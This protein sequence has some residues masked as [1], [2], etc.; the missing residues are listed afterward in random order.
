MSLLPLARS[1][2]IA[3]IGDFAQ[4]A[5]SSPLGT[6]YSVP[7]SD[8][9]TELDGLRMLNNSDANV[10][11][12][13]AMSLTPD[14]A[15][16][17]EPDCNA[18]C[19]T[20][21]VAEYFYNADFS[22]EPAVTR[23]EEGINFNWLYG[24][25]S[26]DGVVTTLDEINTSATGFS[27][28]FSG[29]IVP[30]ITGPQVF[31]VRAD[32]AFRV[33]LDDELILESD[34]EPLSSDLKIALVDSAATKRLKAGK[35][36][37][38]KIEFERGESFLPAIGGLQGLQVSW[39]A[40]N[41]PTDIDQYDAVVAVVGRNFETE[42]EA[43][44]PRFEL[45]EQQATMLKKVT[46]ANPNTIVVMHGG[47]GME[48]RPWNRKAGAVFHA[49]HSGQF[50][51]QALAELIYGDVNPSGKLPITLDKK[52][53]DNPSYDS[54]SDRDDYLGESEDDVMVYSEGLLS[55]YRGY[56][57]DK[58]APLY[59]FG[60]GLS[61]TDFEFSDIKV[62]SRKITEDSTIHV[63]FTLTNT[64]SVAGYN[65]AQLY[66]KPKTS[67]VERPVKE[68]KG[69]AKVWLEAG[70]SKEV[71]IPLHARSFAYYKPE[72]ASWIVDATRYKLLIGDSSRNIGLR[73]SVVAKDKIVM[74][75][76]DSNPIADE[77]KLAI[78][79]SEEETY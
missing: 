47:G 44:D 60:F 79:V 39:A 5:P 3:V 59:P 25:N 32:G 28:R 63:S 48:M 61:Y 10:K 55:G 24:T 18:N 6:A 72:L 66:V 53:S 41:P 71:T 31:K 67:A 76:R 62:D 21:V 30:E 34:G 78:Q 14:T 77:V 22:G 7:D 65:T 57:A 26:H 70:E 19:E 2:R 64:G 54:Y 35:P 20:G 49:F 52:L 17:Q 13:D 45:P 40:L 38:V 1:A 11:F 51:G 8:Y 23:V 69:F 36:Y 74:T 75:T 29:Q 15:D 50:G 12:I 16:W 27:A 73:T 68:L 9:V 4:Q 43:V 42:G 56:D 33:W 46:K 37:Q 58:K